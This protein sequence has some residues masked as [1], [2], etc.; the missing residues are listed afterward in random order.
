MSTTIQQRLARLQTRG[1]E[2]AAHAPAGA[3]DVAEGLSPVH[4]Q[5]LVVI[6]KLMTMGADLNPDGIPQVLKIALMTIQRSDHL[7]VDG[8][9][10]VPAHTIQE[11]MRGIEAEIHSITSINV[12]DHAIA[13]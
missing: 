13:G 5:T 12:D 4:A 9:S 11:F 10:K 6:R 3:A 2:I 8:L 7:M 1:N